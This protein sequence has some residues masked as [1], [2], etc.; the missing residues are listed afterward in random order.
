MRSAISGMLPSLDHKADSTD[1]A[2]DADDA[3]DPGPEDEG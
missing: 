3:D 1:N 2:D